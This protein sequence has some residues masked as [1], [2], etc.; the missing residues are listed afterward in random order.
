MKSDD[1]TIYT[2]IIMIF[3]PVII[4][5]NKQRTV[6]N[7]IFCIKYDHTRPYNLPSRLI[8]VV[9]NSYLVRHG[10]IFTYHDATLLSDLVQPHT[11]K[12]SRVLT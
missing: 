11:Y 2:R 12:H 10:H 4:H 5:G 7:T 8:R 3:L 1:C 6:T 9:C